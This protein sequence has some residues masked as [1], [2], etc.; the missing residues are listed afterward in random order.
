MKRLFFYLF[1]CFSLG[2]V[3]CA[4]AASSEVTPSKAADFISESALYQP[5]RKKLKVLSFNIW[6]GLTPKGAISMGY[7]VGETREY[8]DRRVEAQIRA[9]KDLDPDLIFLQEANP[10]TEISKKYADA[11]NM[12]FIY[13]IDNC[14]VKIFKLGVP[15]P[16]FSGLVIL[17]KKG[18]NL[19]LKKRVKLSGS[20]GFCHPILSLQLSEFRFA[21]FGSISLEPGKEI[22]L[23]N[24][25]L[26]HA[27]NPSF[28]I[29][30]LIKTAQ[31]A[32]LNERHTK[33]F[34]DQV[35]D[36]EK[37]RLA[38][39]DRLLSTIESLKSQKNYFTTILAGD[40]NDIVESKT[41]Q[42][43]LKGCP[44][45][46]V[47]VSFKPAYAFRNAPEPT[48]DTKKSK[49]RE[50]QVKFSFPYKAPEELT[51]KQKTLINSVFIKANDIP[52]KIDYILLGP[53]IKVTSYSLF[54]DKPYQNIFL[55]DH[56]GVLADIEIKLKP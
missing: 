41:V 45:E 23:V 10:V 36:G 39:V 15:Q 43:V 16:I 18:L 19:K 44:E 20:F 8:F 56:F 12:D 13:L 9:I 1:S 38:E 22:L 6:H 55:S 26:H 28:V 31:K 52:K 27:F 2:L 50:F 32:S 5:S 48:Y 53:S 54:G 25:H 37:R 17:A 4:S 42:K 7:L 11:L 3:F 21:L 49:T 24:T 29:E 47:C 46:R 34:I 51:E 30:P 14:G 40:L 35:Y 33:D